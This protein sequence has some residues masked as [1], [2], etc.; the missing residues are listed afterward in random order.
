MNFAAKLVD[1]MHIRSLCYNVVARLSR[2]VPSTDRYISDALY[3]TAGAPGCLL[4][5]LQSG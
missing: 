3:N 1:R 2:R 4:D 5:K